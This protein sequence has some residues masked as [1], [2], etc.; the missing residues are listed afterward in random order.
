MRT[1]DQKS[2]T[3]AIFPKGIYRAEKHFLPHPLLSRVL[4]ASLLAL[5]LV[6]GGCGSVLWPSPEVDENQP[7]QPPKEQTEEQTADETVE[8]SE[9]ENDPLEAA[10]TADSAPDADQLP[11]DQSPGDKISQPILRIVFRTAATAY[12]SSLFSV[13]EM[14]DDKYAAVENNLVDYDILAL[15]IDDSTAA[16][17]QSESYAKRVRQSL[18]DMGVAPDHIHIFQ[19]ALDIEFPMVIVYI[20]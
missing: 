14:L 7:E 9:V 18:L 20:R 12:Q 16:L 3:Y 10:Q 6:I 8:D 2:R 4:L 1:L 19:A 17:E 13:L 5:F 11:A 15:A